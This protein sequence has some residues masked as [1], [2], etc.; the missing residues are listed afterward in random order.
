MAVTIY[1]IAKEV[2]TSAVTVSLA[3]RGSKRV[4]KNTRERIE[5]V[6]QRLGYQPNPLARGLIGAKTKSIAFVFNFP[7]DHFAHDLSY[8]E[9]FH[10]VSVVASKNDYK[11]FVH[12]STKA[13]PIKEVFADVRPYGV[14]G[15]ILGSNIVDANDSK[16]LEN[17][18]IPTVILGRDFCSEK[19]SCLVYGGQDGSREAVR[20]L[21]GLGH[22]R[23]VF[24]GKNKVEASKRRFDGYVEALEE[25]GLGYDSDL[26]IESEWNVENGELAGEKIAKMNPLPTAVIATTDLMAIGVIAGL[27]AGGLNVPDDVSVVGFDNLHISEYSIPSLTSV[28]LRRDLIAKNSMELLLEMVNKKAAGQRREIPSTLFLRD[29]VASCK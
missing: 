20:H 24:A 18:P 25:C 19:V 9:L 27:R 23:I 29:S 16:A 3:L 15:L 26:I 6:A 22:K 10:A 11:L 2:N 21:F 4:S 14:D 1:D 17:A 8:M 13:R 5:N 12:S 7:S 28:D